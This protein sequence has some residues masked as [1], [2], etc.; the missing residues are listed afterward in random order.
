MKRK[1]CTLLL[2]LS[3]ALS[4]LPMQVRAEEG[5]P[6]VIYST[7]EGESVEITLDNAIYPT[8]S[9]S[10]R[11]WYC[12]DAAITVDGTNL[13]DLSEGQSA[14][15]KLATTT[16]V[17][18]LQNYKVIDTTTPKPSGT[19]KTDQVARLYVI[20][21][22][23]YSAAT[24]TTKDLNA[25]VGEEI[26]AKNITLYV[27]STS[28]PNFQPLKFIVDGNI[29]DKI[30]AQEGTN[31]YTLTDSVLNRTVTLKVIAAS[32]SEAPK[33]NSL[34]VT[35]GKA[36]KYSTKKTIEVSATDN[37]ELA[38]DA[39]Y[40]EDNAN[41]STV[42]KE[43]IMGG[44]KA[45]DITGLTWTSNKKHDVTSNGI[46]TAFVKDKAGNISYKDITVSKISSTTPAISTL[47]LLKDGNKAYIEVKASEPSNQPLSYKLNNGSW[48]ES[49]K[50]YNVTEGINKI[51]VR[52][53]AGVTVDSSKE[54]FLSVFMQEE[55]GFSPKNLTNCIQ[56]N[57]STWTNNSVSVS[58]TLP[59]A[60]QNKLSSA[61][62]SINGS[63]YGSSKSITIPNN[64]DTVQFAV[65]DIYG[66][67]HTSNV[68]T[69]TNIDKNEPS[70]EVTVSDDGT[71]TVKAQDVG[72]GIQK[73]VVSSTN[74]SNYVIKTNEATGV[75]SDKATYKA[76]A[77][78]S[79]QFA[80]YDFAGNVGRAAGQVTCYEKTGVQSG[81]KDSK[82]TPPKSTDRS[83]STTGGT[84]GS[85]TLG[86]EQPTR[87]TTTTE[88]RG[89]S[90]FST[91]GNSTR[92]ELSDPEILE[93]VKSDESNTNAPAVMLEK[94]TYDNTNSDA[95]KKMLYI[96]L[97]LL[98]VGSIA[99]VAIVN[100][101]KII[102]IKNK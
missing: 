11:E 6:T 89:Y 79:Y 49:N 69:V 54:V 70:L 84:S 31:T 75:T 94:V 2:S 35:D 27:D 33:I 29:K 19:I 52:N 78:G 81:L 61:P 71:L 50:L 38:Q 21:Q 86:T 18:H 58:I 66:N 63:A 4:I 42:I 22:A 20:S 39:Y 3:C 40:W 51:Y 36:D 12:N 9:S 101:D 57:P 24:L 92:A 96:L 47:T 97:P 7:I 76:P 17:N 55:S 77:N 14:K 32:D 45:S 53:E 72:S 23:N 5:T 44:T 73:I 10:T 100:S 16:T 80:V 74:A 56:V 30:V 62:Y 64:N 28:Y 1:L 65:K 60:L 43:K 93:L 48:Q 13:I 85:S 88:E 95:L 41:L 82:A 59:D 102:K 46:Y 15:L 99:G 34:V 8:T 98:I 91:A 68:Y 87:A 37:I 67:I 83:G 25:T 90:S 26:Y